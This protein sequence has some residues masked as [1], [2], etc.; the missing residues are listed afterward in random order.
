MKI[1]DIFYPSLIKLNLNASSK[2][3]AINELADLIDELNNKYGIK[4]ICRGCSGPNLF[5]N[6][7]G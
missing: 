7:E 2:E 4:V 1:T 5:I 3:E 6:E